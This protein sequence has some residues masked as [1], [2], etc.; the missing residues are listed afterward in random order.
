MPLFDV[1]R[2]ARMGYVDPAEVDTIRALRQHNPLLFDLVLKRRL[3]LGG[4]GLPAS[5]FETRRV[6]DRGVG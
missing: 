1:A 5:V 4:R 3:R 6:F 2:M